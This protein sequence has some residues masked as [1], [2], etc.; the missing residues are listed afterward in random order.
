MHLVTLSYKYIFL[1]PI[2][3]LFNDLAKSSVYIVSEIWLSKEYLDL[4]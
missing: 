3:E 1:W 2:L 4:K